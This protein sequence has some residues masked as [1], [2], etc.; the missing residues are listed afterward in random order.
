MEVVEHLFPLEVYKRL[1]FHFLLTQEVVMVGKLL[2]QYIQLRTKIKTQD[3]G[4]LILVIGVI[5]I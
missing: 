2:I 4:G 3:L 5:Y 1:I